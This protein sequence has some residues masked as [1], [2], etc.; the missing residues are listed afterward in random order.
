MWITRFV[1]AADR[2]IDVTTK[3]RTTRLLAKTIVRIG[4]LI[5]T[6]GAF[7]A[8]ALTGVIAIGILAGAWELLNLL[9]GN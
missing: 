7:L 4:I 8:M 6:V 3:D 5:F 1:D 9:W 2:T